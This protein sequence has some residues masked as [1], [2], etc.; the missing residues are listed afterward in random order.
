M[1]GNSLV[2]M[3]NQIAD[4][5]RYQ[6]SSD[7]AAVNVARHLSHFWA[8][9][10]RRDL[11]ALMEAGEQGISPVVQQA[12]ERFREELTRYGG[13]VAGEQVLEQPKGGGDAG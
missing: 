10:M 3:A 4:F 6:G 11:V 7:E 13:K 12:V 8:L 9:S 2:T 5:F 1:H